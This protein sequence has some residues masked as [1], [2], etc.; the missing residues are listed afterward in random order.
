ML[1]YIIEISVIVKCQLQHFIV[2][3]IDQFNTSTVQI[4]RDKAGY[5][6]YCILVYVFFGIYRSR[7]QR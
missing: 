2:I 1:K 4:Q 3:E 7:D 6:I 5:D